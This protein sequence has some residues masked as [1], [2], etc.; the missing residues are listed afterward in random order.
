MDF[1]LTKK[2]HWYGSLIYER[3]GSIASYNT[4]VTEMRIKI[5]FP[6]KVI[7]SHRPLLEIG[8]VK[9][10]LLRLFP[11]GRE[12][13]HEEKFVVTTINK[14][15][16]SNSAGIVSWDLWIIQEGISIHNTAIGGKAGF[17]VINSEPMV[18]KKDASKDMLLYSDFKSLFDT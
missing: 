4:Y 17:C 3:P 2:I 7:D 9:S 10:W 8:L 15:S 1:Y 11:Y 14:I 18:D 12:S 6:I 13:V 5:D 16:R